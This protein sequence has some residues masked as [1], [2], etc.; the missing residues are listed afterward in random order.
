MGRVKQFQM[1]A[2]G[3]QKYSEA[4]AGYNMSQ[5]PGGSATGRSVEFRTAARNAVASGDQ[6]APISP[7]TPVQNATMN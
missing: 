5:G 4:R 7:T 2:K 1:S 3:M 6:V